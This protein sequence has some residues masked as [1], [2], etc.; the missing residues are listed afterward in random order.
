MLAIFRTSH[1]GQVL[2]LVVLAL[3]VLIGCVALAVDVGM[4]WGVRRKMQTAAD[5]AAVAG[6]VA[7]RQSQDVTAAANNVASLNGY[8]DGANGVIITITNPYSSTV[9][10]SAAKCVKVAIAQPQPT[11]F[12]R[13]LGFSSINVSVSA[14]AGTTNSGSCIYGLGP[15][16]P[17]LKVTGSPVINSQCGIISNN[18]AQCGGNFTVTAPIGV[19]G[20]ANG[21]PANTVTNIS[22]VPDPFASLGSPPTCSGTATQNITNGQT[23]TLTPGSYCGGITIHS[24]AT[25]TFSPGIYNLG[26]G[27]LSMSGGTVNGTGVTFIAT[28]GININGGTVN[29][30]APTSDIYAGTANVKAI[31]FWDT[32]QSPPSSNN[33]TINGASGSTFD[34][35]LYFPKS[36]LSYTGTSSSGCSS[37][38]N[39][40]YTIIVADV[41][42][43]GGNT[44]LCDDYSS[45]PDNL[46]PIQSSS[47]FE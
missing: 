20:T 6:A 39:V 28:T 11:Y 10:T 36:Q 27:G 19:A 5:A 18:N 31:L 4:L 45:L 26:A 14:A 38:S 42:T 40:G 44:S 24:G 46:P 22:P 9:C 2:V 16:S 37:G 1:R 13:V 23:V 25:V 32:A 17:A 21:C 3:V 29:L 34:G 30:S 7:S 8:T 15:D 33:S 43:F 41:V 12:L 35:V 47:L